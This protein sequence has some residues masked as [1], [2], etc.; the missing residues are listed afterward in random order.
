MVLS[1]E[2][3]HERTFHSRLALRPIRKE[4]S[5]NPDRTHNPEH[6]ESTHA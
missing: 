2:G 5:R 1:V 6:V 4:V 3:S